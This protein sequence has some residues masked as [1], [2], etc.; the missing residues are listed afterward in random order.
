V[1][2]DIAARM[3]MTPKQIQLLNRACKMAGID[4]SKISPSNPFEKSGMTA[5][6]LQAA[7]AE[8]DPAQATTTPESLD[9]SKCENSRAWLLK[10]ASRE[11]K[12][13]LSRGEHCCTGTMPSAP[14]QRS[15]RGGL[16]R[17][18][19]AE[20]SLARLGDAPSP[21]FQRGCELSIN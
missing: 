11:R 21:P 15:R 20:M 8:L 19:W 7:I 10:Q 1:I 12:V 13:L 9:S 5:G 4:S 18:L 6:M 16:G 17:A 3:K 2:W 14:H